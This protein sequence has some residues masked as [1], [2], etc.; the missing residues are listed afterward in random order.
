MNDFYYSVGRVRSLEEA[1]M[2]PSQLARMAGAPDFDTA[3]SVLSETPYAENLPKLTQPF[4]FCQ[5]CDL[6]MISLKNLIGHLAPGN[7]ILNALFAQ[8]DYVNI[9][10]LLRAHLSGKNEVEMLSKIGNI[11]PDK[12]KHYIEKGQKDIDDPTIISAID[13]ARNIFEQEKDAEMLDITLDKAYYS[14]LL[15][16]FGA[17][18]SSLI[19]DL[20]KHKIDL[21]NI[22]ILLRSQEI[23]R[24]KKFLEFALLE[25][26][27]LDKNILLSLLDKAVPDIAQR[28]A[29][30][31][32]F[33][34]ISDGIRY[35]ADHQSFYLLEKQMDDFIAEKFH[36]AK[37]MSSGVCPLVGF[38]LA[39]ET[40]LKS[41]RFILICKKNFVDAGQ[42]KERLRVSY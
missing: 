10:I 39:K 24:D 16:I 32:Y 27:F 19:R 35:Y 23:K 40:E 37:Y 3:F 33:P 21:I 38:C 5:L 41:I 1:M 22:K 15:L 25:G 6:E 26:G 4:D 8:F 12:I 31:P 13:Q 42:I 2:T 7:E 20:A 18:L 11:D 28:L 17:S 34:A 9:K 14:S 30:T 29:F 36:Q